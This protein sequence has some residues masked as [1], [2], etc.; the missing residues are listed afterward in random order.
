MSG[1][2]DTSLPRR[3]WERDIPV[4]PVEALREAIRQI[5]AGDLN[6]TQVVIVFKSEADDETWLDVLNGGKAGT[7]E[8]VG[9]LYRAANLLL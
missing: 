2:V 7:D 1:E 5:E 4:A 9:I 6:P 3:R 8:R